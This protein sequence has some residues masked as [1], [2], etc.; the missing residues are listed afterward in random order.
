MLLPE[1]AK[2]FD[3]I[4]IKPCLAVGKK[5]RHGSFKILTYQL[6]EN[7]CPFNKENK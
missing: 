5:P 2:L 1:E 6:T 7:T 4:K 3:R